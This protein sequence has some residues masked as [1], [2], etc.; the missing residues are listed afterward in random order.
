MSTPVQILSD[1]HLE[2]D[3]IE[4]FDYERFKI[5]PKAPTLA[6]L[7]DI[8]TVNNPRLFDFLRVQ[9]AQFE[10]VLYVMGNHEFYGETIV[11][12]TSATKDASADKVLSQNETIDKMKEF[13]ATI[14]SERSHSSVGCF[15]LLHRA[16]FQLSPDTTVLG[17][18]L[19]SRLDD[20]IA[21]FTWAVTDFKSIRGMTPVLYNSLHESDRTWLEGEICRL[22][23]DA[24]HSKI[25]ILTH[26]APTRELASDPKFAGGPTETAFATELSEDAALWR[27]PVGVW[28]FGHTHWSCD[29]VRNGIRVLSNQRG[30]KSGGDNPGKSFDPHLVVEL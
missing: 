27:P 23:E 28:A 29:F 1:L 14:T 26:H 8:G 20:D 6:L 19:W 24:P 2:I 22:A 10:T 18:T 11:S 30:Y 4:G 15:V 5:E 21:D 9:L 25:V 16:T 7:G 12:R 3:R 13:E 17:C